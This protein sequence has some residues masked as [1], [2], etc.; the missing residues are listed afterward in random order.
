M[1]L[2]GIANVAAIF[3]PLLLISRRLQLLRS[4]HSTERTT[5]GELSFPVGVLLPALLI[6]DPMAFSFG[7]LVMGCADAAAA[8][9][10]SRH[11]R[12]RYH[13]RTACKSLQ[14]SAAFLLLSVQLGIAT[15]ASRGHGNVSSLAASLAAAV[16]LV[17]VEAAL[18]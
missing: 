10:G 9:V 12:H 8:V 2:R 17:L 7:I 11:D 4:I 6:P 18:G 13:L 3:I 16:A 15:L 1:T 5:I 14:G